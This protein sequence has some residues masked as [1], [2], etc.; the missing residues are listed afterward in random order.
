MQEDFPFD[1]SG[2]LG[3]D[4]K[5]LSVDAYHY[6]KSDAQYIKHT[7]SIKEWDFHNLN[8]F[9]EGVATNKALKRMGHEQ[10]F[11]LSRSSYAGAGRY[12]AH[13]YCLS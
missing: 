10:I 7:E 4:E 6:A 9:L 11:V 2:G 3:V 12:V 1:P 13:V 8:G 5:T